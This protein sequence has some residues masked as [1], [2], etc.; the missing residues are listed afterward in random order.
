[1]E[2]AMR[3]TRSIAVL[4]LALASLPAGAAENPIEVEAVIAAT[5][6]AHPDTVKLC[7]SGQTGI[8]NAA[9]TQARMLAMEGKIAGTPQSVGTEAAVL[10]G[11]E[12]FGG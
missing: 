12:C 1:M 10:I 2:V 6:A 3:I 4:T 7:Q 11:K 9:S 5:K 8:S